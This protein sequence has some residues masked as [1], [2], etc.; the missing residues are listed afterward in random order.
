MKTKIVTSNTQG[1]L[2]EKIDVCIFDI[3][4]TLVNGPE[5]KA[6]YALYSK[7]IEKILAQKLQLPLSQAKRLVDDFRL[8]N[9]GRGELILEKYNLQWTWYD[10]ILSLDPTRYLKKIPSTVRTL[11]ALKTRGVKLV[12]VTDAPLGQVEKLFGAIGVNSALFEFVIGWEKGQEKP[13]NGR[14][15]IFSRICKLLNSDPQ[16]TIMVGDSLSVD[17]IPAIKAKLIGVLISQKE[18]NIDQPYYCI[19]TLEKLLTVKLTK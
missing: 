3:D 12:A 10:G 11:S 18:F 4:Y 16:K 5:A 17:V 2:L 8:T 9:N 19:P 6:Y 1:L 7:L 13:K 15:E 14:P